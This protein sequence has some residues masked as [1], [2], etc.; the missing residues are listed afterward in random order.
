MTRTVKKVL[1]ASSDIAE[2]QAG[3]GVA[4]A[5]FGQFKVKDTRRARRNPG[6]GETIG[7]RSRRKM[8]V[9]ACEGR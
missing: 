5:G 4:I 1:D 8:Y 7:D 2:S 3:R 9:C 6:T